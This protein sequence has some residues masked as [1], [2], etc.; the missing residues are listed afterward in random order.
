MD[1]EPTLAQLYKIQFPQYWS[2]F[3]HKKALVK[4]TATEVMKA[5]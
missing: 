1:M 2:F 5:K 4:V 3:S